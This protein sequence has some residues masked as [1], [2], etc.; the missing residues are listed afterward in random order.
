MT[1][2]T[3]CQNRKDVDKRLCR[4]RPQIMQALRIRLRAVFD[5]RGSPKEP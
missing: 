3:Y 2:L 4:R 1:Y 5:P